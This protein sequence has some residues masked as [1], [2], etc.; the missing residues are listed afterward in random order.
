MLML[1]VREPH[2]ER[3]SGHSITIHAH[4]LHLLSKGLLTILE[5]K[6]LWAGKGTFLTQNKVNEGQFRGAFV[7]AQLSCGHEFPFS[8]QHR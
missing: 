3:E 6:F 7:R 5:P 2:F 4:L 8:M 1:V